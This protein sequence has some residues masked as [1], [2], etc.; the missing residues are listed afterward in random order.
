MSFYN[1]KNKNSNQVLFKSRVDSSCEFNS[2]QVNFSL[3]LGS[4]KMAN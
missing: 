3:T 1:K 2:L 4:S